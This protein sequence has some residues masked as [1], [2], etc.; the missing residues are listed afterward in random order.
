MRIVMTA[1]NQAEARRQFEALNTL[2]IDIQLFLLFLSVPS[3]PSSETLPVVYVWVLLDNSQAV[4]L[5]FL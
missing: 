1:I 2:K 4:S 3:R 5:L